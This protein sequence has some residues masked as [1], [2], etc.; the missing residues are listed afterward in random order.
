MKLLN[1]TLFHPEHV[2]RSL[3]QW[4]HNDQNREEDVDSDE[5][6][7]SAAERVVLDG[8]DDGVGDTVAVDPETEQGD[9]SVQEEQ[10]W[11]ATKL[12]L[13]VPDKNNLHMKQ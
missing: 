10:R 13:I 12:Q 1:Y 3:Q 4:V 8:A 2:L 11:K 9:R 5:N 7:D 6:G